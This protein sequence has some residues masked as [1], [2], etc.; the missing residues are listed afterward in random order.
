MPRRARALPIEVQSDAGAAA[1]SPAPLQAP[2]DYV[3][4]DALLKLRAEYLVLCE[5]NPMDLRDVRTKVVEYFPRHRADQILRLMDS[6]PAFTNWFQSTHE[7]DAKLRYLADKSLHAL[8]AVLD[9]EHPAAANARVKAIQII[10]SLAG[11]APKS[12]KSE[13]NSLLNAVAKMDA[14]QCQALLSNGT[15]VKVSVK[16]HDTLEAITKEYDE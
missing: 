4:T 6:N 7:F 14:A 10:L 13:E 12:P 3:P 5:H 8:A 16:K 11:K 15:E 2:L 1:T 9:N